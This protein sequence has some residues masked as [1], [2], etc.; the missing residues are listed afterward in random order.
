MKELMALADPPK[1]ASTVKKNEW[2][3]ASPLFK[4]MRHC[5]KEWATAS[6]VLKIYCF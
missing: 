1:E 2:P 6:G 4:A 3:V 5:F